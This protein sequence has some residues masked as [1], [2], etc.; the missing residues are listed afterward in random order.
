MAA[1]EASH[2]RPRRARRRRSAAG[3]KSRNG[4]RQRAARSQEEDSGEEV[5]AAR[6]P[7]RRGRGRGP[8]ALALQPRQ[9]HL[10]RRSGFTK[11]QVIDYYTRVAPAVLPHLR[12][13]PLTLKRYPERRRG[14]VLLREAV[15]LAPARL[16]ATASRS[17]SAARRSSSASATTCRR[18][19]GWRTSPTSSCT[20]SLSKAPRGRAADDDGVRPRPGRAGRRSLECCEVALLAARRARRSSASRASRR[21]RARRASRS[22]CR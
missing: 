14:P 4:R 18:S 19:S 3:R 5:G 16:G 15:P 10:S 1:L 17:R 9:G 21:P 22:T 13:R 20:P 8:A 7:G 11:G 6:A 12:D 2:R